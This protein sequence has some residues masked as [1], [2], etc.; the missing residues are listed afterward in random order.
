MSERALS[1]IEVLSQV[2][3]GRMTAVTA[4]NVLGLSRRQVR[5]LLKRFQTERVSRRS[6]IELSR[7]IYSRIRT[8]ILSGSLQGGIGKPLMV[9]ACIHLPVVESTPIIVPF[10]CHSLYFVARR[11]PS[12]HIAMPSVKEQPPIVM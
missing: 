10:I 7:Q 8:R 9:K 12:W 1:R 3:Q 11:P 4:V 5:R 2:T 6:P